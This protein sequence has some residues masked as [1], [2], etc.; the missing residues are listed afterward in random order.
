MSFGMLSLLRRCW[1]FAWLVALSFVASPARGAPEAKLLRIDP[2]A[3]LE[4]GNPIITTVIEVAQSRRVSEAIIA[5]SSPADEVQR[6]AAILQRKYREPA[7]TREERAKRARFL[8]GRG[9]SIDVI[10]RVLRGT[11]ELV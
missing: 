8:Q 10:S 7:T 11:E 1:V 5:A 4:S 3:S 2:R 6:A 9:F